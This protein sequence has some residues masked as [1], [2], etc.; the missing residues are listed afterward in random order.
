M[1]L[2]IES[3]DYGG[4]ADCVRVSNGLIEIVVPRAI[5]IRVMRL[6][7]VGGVNQFN[8]LPDHMGKTGGDE[9]R[10]Y[11]GH[12]LWHAPETY[13]RTYSLDNFPVDIQQQGDT[14][15]VTQSTDHAGITKQ[16]ELTLSAGAAQVSV[17][18]RLTNTGVWPIPLSAWA[19]SVMAQGGTT[20]APLPPRGA[21]SILLPNTSLVLWPYTHMADPRW[22]WGDAY[23]LLR[24]NPEA[25]VPQKFGL[26]NTQGWGAHWNDGVLFAKRAAYVQGATYPDYG[27]SFEFYTN[28]AIMEV[29]SLGQVTTLLPNESLTH[30]ETWHLWDNVP[31]IHSDADVN[32]HIMPL[33]A[34]VL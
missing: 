15:I 12:R 4:W 26:S 24:Q 3:V 33:I 21:A 30:A 2:Q 19:L 1:T 27:C 20:I 9:W 14:L 32:R 7:F 13:E 16:I 6:A 18:H 17:L 11:G 29:E 8:E 34:G 5:G 10:I 28:N 31:P 22:T 25:T 23:V